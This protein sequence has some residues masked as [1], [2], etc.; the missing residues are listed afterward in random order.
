MKVNSWICV[1]IGLL[2]LTG[3]AS[4]DPFILTISSDKA[5][6]IANGVDQATITANVKNSTSGEILPGATVTFNAD[7]DHGSFSSPSA[8]T[9]SS[10]NAAGTF[11]VKTRSGVATIT[12]SAQ[13][14]DDATTPPTLYTSTAPLNFEQNI[15]HDSPYK[16]QFVYPLTGTVKTN[17]PF[18]AYLQ[19]RWDNPID[20]RKSGEIHT[21]TLHVHGPGSDDG[22][23][24]DG[25]A[26]PH[27][28]SQTL[29]PN[30][31]ISLMVHL[32]SKP[33]INMV[34]MD[35]V[36]SMGNQYKTI[37]GVA[38][39]IPFSIAAVYSPL[40]G[41]EPQVQ[42]STDPA[43]KFTIQ[44][45]LYD[46][47][48]NPTQGQ[49]IWINTTFDDGTPE[50]QLLRTTDWNGQVSTYYGPKDVVS[51]WYIT[52]TA[53][54]NTAV[55]T[56]EILHFVN[57]EPTN[58]DLSASPQN[59]PSLDAN[60]GMYSVVS[61]K[62]IDD[63]GNPA[64]NEEVSFEIS[65]PLYDCADCADK[66]PSFSKSD[67]QTSISAT[68]KTSSPGYGIATVNVYPGSFKLPGETGYTATATGNATVT[69]TWHGVSQ[70]IP[71]VWKNYP[72]LS[73]VTNISP[74]PVTVGKT[75]D[76]NLKLT[77]EGWGYYT[78]AID[79]VIT[80]DRSLTMKTGTKMADA[81]TAG[82]TFNAL[83]SSQD[84]IGL[85]SFG[86]YNTHECSP[87][88]PFTKC[89]NSYAPIDLGMTYDRS[90]VDSI[91][92][93]YK[94]E[95]GTPARE[96]L[97]NATKLLLTN[98]RPGAVQAI[99]I[100][101]DGWWTD[102]GD[103]DAVTSVS[104]ESYDQ[105]LRANWT[106]DGITSDT[107]VVGWA[108]A[109]NI[110]IYSVLIEDPGAPYFACEETHTK[111]WADKTGGKYYHASTSAELAGIYTQI[112]GELQNTASVDTSVTLDFNKIAVNGNV[113]GDAFEYIADTVP[114]KAPGSTMID[115]YNQ[116]GSH[117][118]PDPAY[119]EAGPLRINQTSDWNTARTLNFKMGTIKLGE[120]WETNIRFRV[121]KNGSYS[122]FG[123]NSQVCFKDPK[124]PNAPQSCLSLVNQSAFTATPGGPSSPF[125][126]QNL[127]VSKPWRT[128]GTG[129]LFMEFPIQWTINYT[130]TEPVTEKIYYIHDSDPRVLIGERPVGAGPLNDVV[131]T[132]ILSM[133]PLPL[134]SYKIRVEVYSPHERDN[135]ESD[136]FMYKLSDRP[137][138]KLE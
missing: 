3:M 67:A 83:M 76:I 47:Y 117:L 14:T 49:G 122:L 37:E 12:A 4:A 74:N 135:K 31:H 81:V 56:T 64:G 116:S 29:D 13:W 5:W 111:S 50:N 134:G 123:P 132:Y 97:H 15:D 88:S 59:M 98:P 16:A 108:A 93:T 112:A 55:T 128:D 130:G 82:K 106:E 57:A 91:L 136:S 18:D 84:R 36:G 120:T 22:G 6:L 34:M 35:R 48:G 75:V 20:S 80:T 60:P 72:Y 69:A 68:T 1:L 10:G 45:I 53:V 102:G 70:S 7:S 87:P 9:D 43:K 133:A 33:G 54:N 90:K 110:R 89:G 86:V 66:G 124:D 119:T 62:V 32:A 113:S 25:S 19:D 8:T 126:N 42:A 121:L 46:E 38:T 109:N 95:S 11:K 73:V 101:T 85:V 107:S 99:L 40:K 28:I 17:V 58:L 114:V 127:S 79:M 125:I 118:I 96:A 94:A 23:F 71:I 2:F 61:A 27:D 131:R 44:Y 138:I 115:K 78:K 26:Y 52:A 129:D 24:V 51:D 104:C 92:G 41:S 137:F 63:F 103:P 77:G 30:G 39:G 65:S 21:V 100:V 105:G